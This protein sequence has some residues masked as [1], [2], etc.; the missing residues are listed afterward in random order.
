MEVEL[1]YREMYLLWNIELKI[2][3]HLFKLKLDLGEADN[4]L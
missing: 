1:D 3:S 2:N 4:P